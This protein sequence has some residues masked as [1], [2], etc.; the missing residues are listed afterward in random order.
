MCRFILYLG[1]PIALKSL[2]TD[3]VNSLIHQSY[4]SIETR[5]RL[6]GDGFGIAWYVPGL[7]AD[8][9]AFRSV[10]PAW[11]NRNL[12]DLARVTQSSCVLAHVRAATPGLPVAEANCHPFCHG[13][14]SFMHNGHIGGFRRLK[15]AILGSLS[16]AAFSAIQGSTDS[17]HLMALFL[18]EHGRAPQP[19]PGARLAHALRNTVIKLQE[20]AAA[21]SVQELSYL[22]VAVSDGAACAVMRYSTDPSHTDSLFMNRGRRYECSGGLCRMV[23]PEPGSESAAV[24]I[25]SERLSA[26]GSWERIPEN[27]IVTV[28]PDRGVG[29]APAFESAAVR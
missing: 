10:S 1:P 9:A 25:S 15:R 13:R 27:T 17:E 22:N 29:M 16:D 18:D 4:H 12:L 23:E 5:E 26:D 14:V 3:P 11:N 28:E 19:Q 7:S 6:N 21:E 20:I 8:P 2:I 24:V